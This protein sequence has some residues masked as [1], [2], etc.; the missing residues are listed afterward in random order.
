MA[1]ICHNITTSPQAVT[2]PLMSPAS[3]AHMVFAITELTENILSQGLG[4]AQLFTLRRINRHFHAAITNSLA[5]QQQMFVVHTHDGTDTSRSIRINPLFLHMHMRFPFK[6]E[7]FLYK[8]TT[9]ANGGRRFT[10]QLCSIPFVRETEAKAI[11]DMARDGTAGVLSA[12]VYNAPVALSGELW[13]NEHG[14]N[15]PSKRYT[16]SL[17]DTS[18]MGEVLA[19]FVP[20]VA[21]LQGARY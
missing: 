4:V 6:I 14:F 5:L 9:G 17:S 8:K 18:S 21:Q 3:A 19:A 11:H 12:K 1:S 7:S 15:R 10:L 13:I 20:G 16:F 2:Q